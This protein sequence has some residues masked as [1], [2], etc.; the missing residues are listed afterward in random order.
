M[1]PIYNYAYITDAEEGLILTNVNTLADQEPRNN[2]LSRALTWNEGGVLKGRA[3][4]DDRRAP[5]SMSAPMPASSSSTWT[6]RSTR[7]S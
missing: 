5:V 3:P 2:F 4:S 1:H 7:R 6:T